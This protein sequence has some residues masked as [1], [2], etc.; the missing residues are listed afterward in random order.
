M[1]FF[2]KII[3]SLNLFKI[4]A[5]FIMKPIAQIMNNKKKLQRELI[6]SFSDNI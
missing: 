3:Y 6:R 2:Y 1:C 4:F 5:K